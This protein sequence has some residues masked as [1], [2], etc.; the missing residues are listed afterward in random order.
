VVL[1]I[2]TQ[3]K[4]DISFK[5]VTNSTGA[6]DTIAISDGNLNQA[7]LTNAFRQELE[8][9]IPDPIVWKK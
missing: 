6:K 5:E 4:R 1:G 7:Y 2:N 3:I 8:L 9:Y